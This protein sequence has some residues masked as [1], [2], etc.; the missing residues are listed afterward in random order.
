MSTQVFSLVPPPLTEGCQL[1]GCAI[2]F[3][4]GQIGLQRCS[5]CKAVAYCSRE[6]QL[7]NWKA[8]K[9]F[10]NKIK[11]LQNKL[12]DEERNLLSSTDIFQDP[13]NIGYF[14][15]LPETNNYMH[16]R[17]RV[18]WALAYESEGLLGLKLAVEHGREMLRLCTLDRLNVKYILPGVLV[19][20]GEDQRAY[21]LCRYWL[22]YCFE[23][24]VSSS[25]GGNVV[26]RYLRPEY[27]N[28]DVFEPIPT[29]WLESRAGVLPL[30]LIVPVTLLKLRAYVDLGM[31]IE[32]FGGGVWDVS[33]LDPVALNEAKSQRP[34]GISECVLRGRSSQADNH[35][36]NID[37]RSFW[38]LHSLLSGQL[39][40]LLGLINRYNGFF[41]S[42]LID[43]DSGLPSPGP[44]SASARTRGSTLQ[45]YLN[46]T[47]TY[48]ADGSAE[49][50]QVL[51]QYN[52]KSW[53]GDEAVMKE[54]R[55]RLEEGA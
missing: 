9:P 40:P 46:A 1:P 8:H 17:K 12:E 33:I 45:S 18:F 25:E 6:H 24:F 31:L 51:V 14:G 36:Q 39:T 22:D 34:F 19:R 29:H 27:L 10:C 55:R 41:L 32:R 23:P 20:I 26:E 2:T 48:Y 49:E 42:A 15:T 11:A 38:N 52:W 43:S 3:S 5:V 28:R 16:A 4:S 30:G 54:V 35:A 44:D 13:K 53:V 21:D 7:D 47:P 50:A 37:R